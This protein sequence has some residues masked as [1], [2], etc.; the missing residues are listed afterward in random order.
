MK[1]AELRDFISST[2]E[3]FPLRLLSLPRSVL[4]L[5]HSL[6]RSGVGTNTARVS[7]RSRGTVLMFQDKCV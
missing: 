7:R 6:D 2:I 1:E 3:E 4:L 5:L